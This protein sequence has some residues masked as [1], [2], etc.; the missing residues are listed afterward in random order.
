M[1]KHKILTDKIIKTFYDVHNE[2]GHGFLERVYQNSIFFALQ[3][4]GLNVAIQRPFPVYFRGNVVG[5]YFA[6]MVVNDLVIVEL[7]AAAYLIEAHENQLRNYLKASKIEIG[8]LMNFGIEPTFKR[9]AWF[10][11]NT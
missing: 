10:N 2:L 8:L 9:I 4:E 1:L 5:E 3:E 11:K 6:D 7:K